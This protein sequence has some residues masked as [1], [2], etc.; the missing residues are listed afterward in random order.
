MFVD[1]QRP[2]QVSGRKAVLVGPDG[3]VWLDEPLGN[4]QRLA[5]LLLFRRTLLFV[6]FIDAGF[7]G[8]AFGGPLQFILRADVTRQAAA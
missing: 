7:A 2:V 6:G 5:P 3:W 1:G 8:G 4:L